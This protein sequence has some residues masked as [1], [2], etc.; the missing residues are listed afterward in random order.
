MASSDIVS[1]IRIRNFT[2]LWIGSLGS[3]FAM[4]MQIIAR[5]WYVYDLTSSAVDLA[6]VT[7]SFMLPTV[8]FSLYG[9]VIADRF[10]KK[11]I[12]VYAQ[13]MNFIATAMMA[14][15]IITERVS[16]WD[17]MWVGLFNGT[18]LAL[19]M[20][21]RQAF[22]PDLIPERLIF[23]AMGLTTS[24]WNISRIVGPAFAGFLIAVIAEGDKTSSF[25][26]GI[27]YFI[28]AALYLISAL[29]MLL[30]DNPGSPAGTEKS[31]AVSEMKEGLLYVLER[32]PVFG[33]IILSVIPFL[34][35]MSLNTLLPAFNQDMLA[36]QADDLG[37]LI[38]MMGV[39]A[40]VGSLMMAAM[41]NIENK[42]RW[43][44]A[45]CLFWGLAT[46]LFGLTTSQLMAMCVIVAFGWLMSWN[47]SM[48][49]GLLQLQ[50]DGHMRGRIMSIDMMSHGLMPLGVFPI[51]IIADYYDVGTAL[52]VSG[53]AFMI[54]TIGAFLFMPA[55][56]QTD[57]FDE[58]NKREVGLTSVTDSEVV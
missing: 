19:S 38:S 55:V 37:L 1:A 58:S 28:I 6:W 40:I 2:W 51:S 27:V 47:M 24:G 20:P 31:G 7:V 18:V 21:A 46:S 54:A 12:I 26:V 33:L 43:L 16:F 57:V 35:G 17:F 34:F 53:I 42:G 25:G 48:N 3:S 29:T 8:L 30:I 11:K 5:G 10:S 52:F 23:T 44:I 56:R 32:P 50:V 49:R 15:I 39:G 9:G 41:G 22:V 36:G 45:S 4:N 14:V 13:A